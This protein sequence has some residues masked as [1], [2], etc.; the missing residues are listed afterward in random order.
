MPTAKQVAKSR[1]N[2]FGAL[3]AVLGFL[4]ANS[5]QLR[6]LMPE[7]AYGWIVLAIGAAVIALRAV[8]DSPLS[9]K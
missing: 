3:I 7:Q 5:E 4:Q 8:T 6:E 9:E 2:R 1:T